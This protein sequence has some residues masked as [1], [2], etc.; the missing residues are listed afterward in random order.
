MVSLEKNMY[1]IPN[2]CVVRGNEMFASF[3]IGPIPA[4]KTVLSM[5]LHIPVPIFGISIPV[6]VQELAGGWDEALMATGFVP[7]RGPVI[8][9]VYTT[10]MLNECS[11]SL[12]AYEY[13]WRFSSLDNHGLVVQMLDPYGLIFPYDQPPYLIVT[14]D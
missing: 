4:D 6:L 8:A 11:T 14:T 5:D 9:T 3:N 10:P 2:R 12:L 1:F 7:A 13:R